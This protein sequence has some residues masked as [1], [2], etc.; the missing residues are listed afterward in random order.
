MKKMSLQRRIFTYLVVILV[1]FIALQ[2]GLYAWVEYHGW[3]QHPMEPLGDELEEVVSALALNL[4]LLPVVLILAWRVSYRMLDPVRTIADTAVR[5]SG[6]HFDERINTTIMADDEM[7]RLAD[8]INAA[9]N[10]YA[11]AVQRL[12]QFAGDASH[13]LR[14][15]LAALRTMGEVAASR[16]RPAAE[17]REV[18]SGMLQELDRLRVVIEQLLALSRMDQ[19]VL[20][21]RF[22]QLD[23]GEVVAGVAS[24][25]GPV[26]EENGIHLEQ[27]GNPGVQMRGVPELLTEML[28]NLVDNAI[29]HTSWGGTLKIGCLS[30]SK[31]VVLFVHDSGPGIAEDMA[32][33]VFERFFQVPDSPGGGAGLGLAVARDIALLH[34]GTLRVA[35]PGQ[36][37]ARF[38]AVLPVSGKHA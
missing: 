18:I 16:E 37:G 25:Y 27:T 23:A 30:L 34:G 38:E 3:A 33:R 13:Q 5:I 6:G 24:L 26:C 2:L 29:R 20:R 4:V 22:K 36:S 31:D 10:R 19:S 12:K 32:E 8:A 15:P 9:F 21:D 28:G 1:V 17:Y 7:H 35:N 11:F 14:T